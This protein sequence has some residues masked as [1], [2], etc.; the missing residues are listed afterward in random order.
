MSNK[1]GFSNFRRFANFPVIDLGD[2]TILVGGNNSGK[3]TLVKALLL[4]VD[5]IRL[6]RVNDRRKDESKSVLTASMPLFRFDANEYHDVKVKTFARA[7]HNKPVN[8]EYFDIKRGKKLIQNVLTSSIVFEFTLGQFEFKIYVSGD[9]DNLKNVT[10]GDV[11]CITIT[12]LKSQVRYTN[13]YVQHQMSYEVLNS[14]FNEQITLLKKLMQDF[15]KA[16]KEL[17]KAND[18]GD[19]ESITSKTAVLDKI[20]M[21]INSMT[22]QDEDLDSITEEEVRKL[23]VK[24]LREKKPAQALYQLPLSFALNEVAEPVVLNVISNIMNFASTKGTAPNF[25][26]NDSLQEEDKILIMQDFNLME[27]YRQAMAQDIDVIRR[28][29]NDLKVLLDNIN[30][31][32]TS[33]LTLQLKIPSITQLIEMIISRRRYMSFIVRKFC[34]V[35]RSTN[36]SKTGCNDSKSASASILL[37]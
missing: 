1:I 25:K 30:V 17:D 8:V 19:L 31:E 14:D 27:K 20:M 29:Y 6:M 23:M 24:L 13:D 26:S 33:L 4:C 2:V 3:S 35:R 32:S 28:S 11:S 12:D 10:T 9:R 18:E 37:Q 15:K 22:D 16:N 34:P 36:L 7:I 5:N 21:Q